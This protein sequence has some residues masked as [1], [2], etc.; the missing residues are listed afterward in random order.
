MITA[1]RIFDD[2]AAHY[3]QPDGTPV[4]TV[5]NKS[6]GGERP[7]TLADAKKLGLLPS[8]T[9]ILKTLAKPALEAW[10]IEQAVLACLTSPKLEDESLDAFVDRILSTDR[11]QDQ[12]RDAAARKGR[13]IHHALQ[14]LLRDGVN[15]TD[16]QEYT[17]PV[18]A[19]LRV[20]GRPIATE[21]T[22]VTELY[23]GT[24]DLLLENDSEIWVID[25]KC[26]R[27]I[28]NAP[29]REHRLQ[30]AAYAGGLGNTGQKRVRC[31]NVYIG[32]LNPGEVKVCDLGD[33]S[34]DLRCFNL[35]VDFW[36]LSNEIKRNE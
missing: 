19:Q 6:K 15:L 35:L 28:P 22:I 2:N 31:A 5:P 1:A 8:P 12:E 23:V 34:N 10:K 27:N 16:W 24:T 17:L 25:F 18:C 36:Y 3:Y 4:F 26:T 9:T 21:K 14:V 29:Y 30:L 13:S 11:E 32:T 7:T 33:W 20:L